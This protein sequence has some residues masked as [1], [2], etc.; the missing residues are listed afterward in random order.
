VRNRISLP[1]LAFKV[2]CEI[3]IQPGLGRFLFLCKI[4]GNEPGNLFVYLIRALVYQRIA[5]L[6]G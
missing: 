2:V 3:I 5:E 1:N 4:T 6:G